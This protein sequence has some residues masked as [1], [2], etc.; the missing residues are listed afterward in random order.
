M[1]VTV[2]A[3]VAWHTAY[4]FTRASVVIPDKSRCAV[5]S[6][7]ERRAA[8]RSMGRWVDRSIDGSFVRVAVTGRGPSISRGLTDGRTDGLAGGLFFFVLAVGFCVCKQCV[9]VRT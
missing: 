3:A 5:P 2:V 8:I 9:M 4:I 7:N 1:A 6:E